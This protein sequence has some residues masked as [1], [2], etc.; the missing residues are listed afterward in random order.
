MLE[1]LITFNLKPTNNPMKRAGILIAL[2][3]TMAG[4]ECKD[5]Y[6]PNDCDVAW[7]ANYAGTWSGTAEC[8]GVGQNQTFD[9]EDMGI[10]ADGV[11]NFII[12][13][14]V[15]AELGDWDGFNIPSQIVFDPSIG[16]NMIVSGQG[17]LVQTNS[18]N[19][20]GTLIGTT[21]TLNMRMT[22]TVGNQ[23]IECLW[24]LT[25]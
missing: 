25:K 19:T 5:G 13:G 23:S 4:C 18:T 15:R 21:T 17:S 9:I 16:E 22:Q 12:D 3:L 1:N 20:G 11:R 7:S 2:A 8:S 10:A 24:R 14:N 6:G